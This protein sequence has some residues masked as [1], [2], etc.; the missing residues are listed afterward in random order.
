MSFRKEK[1]LELVEKARV[2]ERLAHAYLITGPPNSG[3]EEIAIRLIEMTIPGNPR[4]AQSLDDLRG[5][6]T[7]ILGPESKSRRIT[8]KAIR[9][10]E[11]LLHMASDDDVTK[12]AVIKDADCLGVEAENAFLK[13]LEEPPEGSRL[14]LI[15]S[16]PEMLLDTILSR[17]IRIDLT[18][19]TGPAPI[20]DK[21]RPF[22]ESLKHHSIRGIKGVSGALGL[23]AR[24]SNLLH[25]EKD[26]VSKHNNEEYKA[27]VTHYQ[28]TTEGSWL[29]QREEY[30]K[31]L[32]E[33][34]YL[35]RR[36]QLLEYLIMW[37]GDALRQ[38]NGG[39]RLDLP[40]FADATLQLAQNS[41][42][43][44]LSRK[45]D[46][47]DQLRS[48]LNTNATESLALEVGFIKAFG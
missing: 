17:C 43:D 36:N 45:V 32:T 8:V 35:N 13:T 14:I 37:F 24:F 20:P 47:I 38:Q 42:S 25:E 4:L 46:A 18:G 6:T 9:E 26:L 2:N 5:P 10:A 3:K 40:E 39:T 11:H 23:M 16:R 28:K 48:H 30:Y 1:A 7:V 15:T 33:S 21:V 19:E 41:T 27:E 44:E 22:L 31:A 29:K 34:Q 12:F